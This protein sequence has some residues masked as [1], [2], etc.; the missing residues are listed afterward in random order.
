[1]IGTTAPEEA[2]HV[3]TTAILA[4]KV[5]CISMGDFSVMC[6]LLYSVSGCEYV[7]RLGE[8]SHVAACCCDCEELDEA[9]DR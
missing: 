6:L 2:G 1:M 7:N 3:Q 4:Y 8:R 5:S 9:C